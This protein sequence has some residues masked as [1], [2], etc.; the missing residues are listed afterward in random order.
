LSSLNLLWGFGFVDVCRFC[1]IYSIHD[2][3]KDKEFELEMSW[4]CEASGKKFVSVPSALLEAAVTAAKAALLG[5]D[6]EDMDA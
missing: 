5:S 3:V 6:V 2:E 4:V 1:S